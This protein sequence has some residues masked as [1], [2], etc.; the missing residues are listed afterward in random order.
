MWLTDK[1]RVHVSLADSDTCAVLGDHLL[2]ID[3]ELSHWSWTVWR[4]P[5]DFAPLYPSLPLTAIADLG[6]WQLLKLR[7]SDTEA[8]PDTAALEIFL[9]AV[10]DDALVRD[11]RAV[12]VFA[13]VSLSSFE[14]GGQKPL[15]E[16]FALK[17]RWGRRFIDRTLE[18]GAR[19][20]L[21]SLSRYTEKW[22]MLREDHL[23]YSASPHD[24]VELDVIL[25]DSSFSV[26]EVRPAKSWFR[27]FKWW[28]SGF[29]NALRIQNGYRTLI[30]KFSNRS[31]LLSWLHAITTAAAASGCS[32]RCRYSAAS[33]PRPLSSA[34]LLVDGA[35]YYSELLSSLD[36]ASSDVFIVGWWLT[37]GIPLNRS[38]TASLGTSQLS[39]VLARIA[40]RGV[41][42]FIVLYQETPM[43]L[44][45]DS[46]FA[47]ETLEDLHPQNIKVVCHPAKTGANAT[48]WW[49]H[50]QKVVVIDHA[51]AFVGGI[52]LCLGRYDN[53]SHNLSDS[54]GLRF[55]GRDYINFS[56]RDFVPGGSEVRN[57]LECDPLI[58]RDRVARLPWHD[59]AVQLTGEAIVG[60]ISRHFVQLWNHVKTDKH[61]YSARVAFLRTG[62]TS[63]AG[64]LKRRMQYWLHRKLNK[65]SEEETS[66]ESEEIR[67]PV[68]IPL[69]RRQSTFHSAETMPAL[70]TQCDI[71]LLRSVGRWSLGLGIEASVR[72]AYIS[73]IDQCERYCY[74]E[75]QFFI[76]KSGPSSDRHQKFIRNE[77]GVSLAR[78]I[79]RAE[80]AGDN[81]PFKLYIVLPACPAFQRGSAADFF[82]TDVHTCRSII[83][84]MAASLK[85][86][87][88]CVGK[89]AW[90][91]RVRVH[92]LRQFEVMSDGTV[93]AEQIYVHSKVMVVDDKKCII[94]SANVNDR[95]LLG[96]RDS[97]VCVLIESE[98]FALQ[99]RMTLWREHLDLSTSDDGVITDPASDTC[100]NYWRDTSSVNSAVYHSSFSVWPHNT[101]RTKE[102]LEALHSS[103]LVTLNSQEAEQLQRI[104]GR[105][106]DYAIDFLG[107][108]KD[109][110][111]PE[112]IIN[113]LAP[114]ELG[115]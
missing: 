30:V 49:S 50:H 104:R 63:R 39:S 79:Q 82:T 28:L 53:P 73:L 111:P 46:E 99:T 98:S 75:N 54:Q 69:P 84:L 88:H 61:K 109:I 106:V 95:S 15:K 23:S 44:C 101:I 96:G 114:R 38:D 70:E 2:R 115:H 92:S 72:E 18:G 103:T 112:P 80:A 68:K 12:R 24:T 93:R 16:G 1:P 20:L 42:V 11:S 22:L 41:K 89:A 57:I 8:L 5:A 55:P 110:V 97:E 71:Q 51:I 40:A 85:S 66:E 17:R 9:T 107:D 60:D 6:W 31:K 78:R 90:A 43:V 14:E 36:S 102:A 7:F 113:T 13:E 45:N 3:F 94:G 76:T 21:G 26:E 29:K 48:Y 58:S 59:V 37:P 100:F 83:H 86:L 4:L 87:R 33:P 81:D 105:L 65:S 25:F 64:Q 27:R 77:V 56:V 47:K 62:P 108:V 67:S 34:R 19:R 35:S 91:R 52:D 74:I 32:Q 10:L